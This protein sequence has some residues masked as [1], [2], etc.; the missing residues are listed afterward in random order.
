MKIFKILLLLFLAALVMAFSP[1]RCMGDLTA[2]LSDNLTWSG[3]GITATDGW[4]HADTEFEYAVELKDGA[5]G[6]YYQYY[7]KFT[8]PQKG[9]SHFIIEVSENFALE[10]PDYDG[11]LTFGPVDEPV[12]VQEFLES[13]GNPGIPGGGFWGIKFNELSEGTDMLV[14]EVTFNSLRMPMDGSFYAKD[15]EGPIPGTTERE[16]AIAYNTNPIAVPD[17]EYIPVPGAVLL[18]I[19][20]LGV[21]G[22]K[23]RKF[24]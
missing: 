4:M 1:Q 7:Y 23:L 14:F 21:A 16:L 20:G 18:G 6:P 19:L 11:P 13:Q 24:A 5:T 12:V 8:V 15:G 10:W 17:T 22:I 9:I 2:P 3:G